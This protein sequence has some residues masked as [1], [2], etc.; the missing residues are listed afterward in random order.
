MTEP[1]D[2]NETEVIH[3][4]DP[5]SNACPL[6]NHAQQ[7]EVERSQEPDP[8]LEVKRFGGRA[9]K[10]VRFGQLNSG[11]QCNGSGRGSDPYAPFLS[12]TDWEVY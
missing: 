12:R 1:A 9:G 6:L 3:T 5:E 2:A 11:T 8:L 4:E 10:P 7:A